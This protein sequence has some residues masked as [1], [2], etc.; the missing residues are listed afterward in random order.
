MSTIDHHHDYDKYPYESN[1]LKQTH[2]KHLFALGQCSGLHPIPVENARVLELGCAS[3]GNIIPMAFHYPHATFTGLDYSGKQI[4][5]GNLDIKAL[6]LSNITLVHQSILDFNDTNQKFDYILCHGMYSW[7]E[8]AVRKQIL[9][10]CHDNLAENGLAYISY[11]TYPGWVMG[12]TLRD[13]ILFATKDLASPEQKIAQTRGLLHI[14]LETLSHDPTPYANLL[15][16]EVNLVLEHSDNQLIHEH[17]GQAHYPFFF[18]EFM[19]HIA[20][21]ELAYVCDAS[22]FEKLNDTHQERDLL[23][24]RRF[25]SSL[26]S[27]QNSVRTKHASPKEFKSVYTA[28]EP[29]FTHKTFNDKPLACPLVRYMAT[30]QDHVTN[31]LHENIR[32]SPIAQIIIPY[33]DGKHDVPALTLIIKNAIAEDS[34]IQDETAIMKEIA[35][36]CKETLTLMAQRE[37]LIQ[38]TLP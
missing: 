9:T 7:V 29:K 16:N 2:P 18:F 23:Q 27:H 8:E 24:N 35:I 21:Y 32:L 17:L 34:L 31:R 36:L 4:D 10:I 19:E 14:L 33:L 26:I 28:L 20:Q 22:F 37:L 15:L 13:M 30:K 11:N 12:N 25:R 1:A 38:R 6:K 5:I 3:G